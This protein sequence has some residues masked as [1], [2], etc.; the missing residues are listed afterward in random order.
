MMANKFNNILN[1]NR[2]KILIIQMSPAIKS[3]IVLIL[4][5]TNK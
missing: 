1:N 5:K 3:K 4:I 2:N